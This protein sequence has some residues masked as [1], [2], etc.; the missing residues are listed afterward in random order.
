MFKAWFNM[1]F[2]LDY[3]VF[4]IIGSQDHNRKYNNIYNNMTLC[5]FYSVDHGGESRIT[6]GLHKCMYAHTHTH[7][8]TLF[9]CFRRTLMSKPVVKEERDSS[10][11]C[12][13]NLIEGHKNSTPT[14][15]P[16]TIT[17]HL[18]IHPNDRKD[19]M[20]VLGNVFLC[21]G[22]GTLKRFKTMCFKL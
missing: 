18:F 12:V 10:V 6:A 14:P 2:Y 11:L 22:G 9:L 1:L 3:I 15:L 5:V 19:F 16:P 13:K 17:G 4:K 7:T 8:H 20:T 21:G